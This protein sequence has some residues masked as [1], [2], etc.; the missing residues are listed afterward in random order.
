MHEI[1][2]EG[3][4]ASAIIYTVEDE[5]SAL[6]QHALAQVRMLCDTE[7]CEGSVI[8]VMPDVHAGKVGPVGLTMSIGE[9]VMPALIGNDIGCGVTITQIANLKRGLKIDDCQRLDAV[10][11]ERVPS[12]SANR[13]SPHPW[14]EDFDLS[15]LRCARHIQ[16]ER[17]IA[18]LGTLGGGNHFIEV[19]CK[20]RS[21]VMAGAFECFILDDELLDDEQSRAVEAKQDACLPGSHFLVVHSGSRNLGQQVYDHYMRVGRDALKR[22]G[23][24]VPYEMTWLEGELAQDYLHDVQIV[25][26]FAELNRQIMQREI[27]RG[28]KW[29]SGES[30]SSMHNYIGADGILRKGAVS[31]R[32]G[33]KVII[34]TNMRDGCILAIGKGNSEWNMSAPHGSGRILMRTEVKRRHT[35]SEYRK[36]MQGVYCSC[37]GPATLDE[38][39]FA[40]KPMEDL[41]GAIE[42]TVEHSATLVP[43]YCFKAGSGD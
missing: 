9:R 17:A 28:M 12:G 37:I 34:P 33:E 11:R 21:H 4:C 30:F 42:S 22:A 14:A 2:V 29:K 3:T 6:D 43:A 41:V 19:D 38:A 25:C 26:R 39:P 32:A 13:A 24:N 40:Y 7:A 18:G 15:E 5:G 1:Y 35:V 36:E 16:L 23:L 31:A 8:R 20:D 10:I 27:F